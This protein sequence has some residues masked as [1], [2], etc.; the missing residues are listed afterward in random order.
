MNFKNRNKNLQIQYCQKRRAVDTFINIGSTSLR[1]QPLHLISRI[2]EPAYI[3]RPTFCARALASR[4]QTSARRSCTNCSGVLWLLPDIMAFRNCRFVGARVFCSC[5][6]C[7]LILQARTDSRY[8]NWHSKLPWR[9][10]TIGSEFPCNSQMVIVLSDPTVVKVK[11]ALSA[12]RL[13]FNLMHEIACNKVVFP[14]NH[15]C[16]V[17]FNIRQGNT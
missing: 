13:N 16:S 15:D 9:I 14:L 3:L 17:H 6:L 8:I 2:Y 7:H 10:K 1:Q 11:I 12:V 5:R 4:R